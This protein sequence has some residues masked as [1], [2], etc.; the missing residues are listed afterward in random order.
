VWAGLVDLLFPPRCAGCG[1]HGA[2]FCPPCSAGLTRVRPPICGRCGDPLDHAAPWC[3]VCR[4]RPPPYALARSLAAYDGV[5]RDAIRALKFHGRRDVA[6]PLG[7]LLA[8]FASEAICGEID[9]VVPVPLH[10]ARLA[11]RGFNQAALLAQPVAWK[12]SASCLVGALR[13]VHQEAPQVELGAAA[14]RANVAGAFAPGRQAVRG[15]VLLV[16]DVFST[17][18]T[19]AAC[20]QTLVAMGA[21]RVVVLTLARAILSR[22]PPEILRPGR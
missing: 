1:A 9:A 14:R 5:L 13:R 3:P 19:A 18:A 4:R 10:P 8:G 11:A 16:D 22:N 15:T 7:R 20:A 12:M 21:A 2:P 6:A 17:G